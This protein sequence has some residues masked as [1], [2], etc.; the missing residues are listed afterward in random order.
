MASYPILDHAKVEDTHERV[1]TGR[2]GTFQKVI[3]RLQIQQPL[4]AKVAVKQ[5]AADRIFVPAVHRE[6]VVHEG[7]LALPV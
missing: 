3:Q 1:I 2:Q 4:G 5:E 7:A 6:G